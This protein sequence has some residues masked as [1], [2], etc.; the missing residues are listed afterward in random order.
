MS[1]VLQQVTAFSRRAELFQP[2]DTVM[3]ACSGGP[4][5]V[6]LLHAL[7]SLRRLLRI[8]VV[9]FHFDHRLHAASA[10]HAA[11]VRRQAAKLRVA[12]VVR[13]AAESPPAGASVEAW[14]RTVRY[15][16][17]SEAA[18]EAGADRL[19]L[20]HTMDDQA[21]TV[22]LGL[23]RGGGLEAVAG[24]APVATA[25]PLGLAAVRPLLETRREETAAFC[26]SLGLRPRQDPANADPRF[27]R[28]RIRQRV[29]PA[30]ERELDRGLVP[31]LART[32]EH[33][34]ADA[35]FL[36]GLASEAAG[37]IVE[38]GEGEVRL[39]AASLVAL[40]LPVASRV[41]RHALRL[42][43]ALGGELWGDVEASHVRAVLDLAA[44]RPKRR[45]D[46]PGALAAVRDREYVRLSRGEDA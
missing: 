26:R 34:R 4:D 19:A 15:A 39:H 8:S 17:L 35:A 12:F 28:V 13:E 22:L 11:Y 16:A 42:A 18:V 21:E 25:P 24:M 30:L 31:T 36:E 44:G 46:L 3:V 37:S 43:A 10:E 5:S 27:L 41:V 2:R 9:A 23:A 45:A 38:I 6:C 33:V 1:R 14:A 32:A 20:G 7:T 29:L 40:P